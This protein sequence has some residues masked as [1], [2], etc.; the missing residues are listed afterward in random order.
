M[1]SIF[2]PIFWNK[3]FLRFIYFFL[4]EKKQ[5]VL[6]ITTTMYS[7]NY[8]NDLL[9]IKNSNFSIIFF[10]FFNQVI[11][12]PICMARRCV[13]TID[14]SQHAVSRRRKPQLAIQLSERDQC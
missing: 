1:F 13:Y 3:I 6:C 7:F 10:F 2:A 4:I 11:K 9:S 14:I 12:N 8:Y 5:F